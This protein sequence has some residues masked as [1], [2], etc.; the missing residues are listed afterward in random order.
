MDQF[1]RYVITLTG[2]NF[3]TAPTIADNVI[4]LLPKDSVL[5]VLQEVEGTIWY[6]AQLV[7][8]GQIGYITSKSIYVAD[9]EP[10]WLTQVKS[11]INF[12]DTYL[13]TPYVFGSSRNTDQSF[14]C[15]DFIRWGYLKQA[16]L[17]IPTNSRDQAQVGRVVSLEQLRTGDILFYDTN[18]DGVINH[19]SLFVYPNK[20]LHTYSTTSDVYD[21]DL[22]KIKDNSGG[23]TY[24]LYNGS[25]EALY[26]SR[27]LFVKRYIDDEGN[28]CL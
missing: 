17:D 22:V 23:V 9:F 19:C 28:S 7:S 27:P 21:K 1:E 14:D 11:I 18:N 3:R 13:G 6:Q 16:G 26:S 4:S 5:R 12:L 15:S 10:P 2:V 24:N 8:S 20:I 25:G